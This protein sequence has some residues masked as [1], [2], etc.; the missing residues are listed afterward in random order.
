MPNFKPEDVARV[1]ETLLFLSEN[2][3]RI[4]AKVVDYGAEVADFL[5]SLAEEADKMLADETGGTDDVPPSRSY[6]VQ[7]IKDT[8]K[9]NLGYIGLWE[10]QEY[11]DS[12][13]DEEVDY[14]YEQI[15]KVAGK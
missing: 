1:K 14:H 15:K 9:K 3:D 8:L 6:K 11:I 7:Y 4:T 13:S 10:N 2:I 12:V 5:E